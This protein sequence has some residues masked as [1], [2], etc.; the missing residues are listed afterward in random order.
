[1]DCNTLLIA[2]K[3]SLSD[4]AAPVIPGEEVR[5]PIWSDNCIGS[6]R[7]SGLAFTRIDTRVINCQPDAVLL[8]L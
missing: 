2:V 8:L 3:P 1:M 5:N 6:N 4:R 7:V